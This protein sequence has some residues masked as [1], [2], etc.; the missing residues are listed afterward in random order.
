MQEAITNALGNSQAFYAMEGV[1]NKRAGGGRASGVRGT[2]LIFRCAD[3]YI[4]Y[5]RSPAT[6]P[7]LHQWMM[8]EG[9]EPGFDPDFW[10][11]RNVVGRDAP[12]QEQVHELEARFAAFFAN[13]PK[14]L[15]YEEG[16]D[17]GTQ[18]CPVATVLDILQNRQLAHR[19][20]FATVD[21]PELQRT[22]TYPGAPFK[23]SRSPWQAGP[24]APQL[25][26]HQE[27]ILG[28]GHKPKGSVQHD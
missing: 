22:F 24:A 14:M 8:D 3:G 9:F 4:A 18:I 19:K 15:L 1:V 23:M 10:S 28:A 13:R 6:V 7:L 17:R 25:G 2:R 12:S 26:E 21:H 16:Q 5:L 20:F 27:E 11:R